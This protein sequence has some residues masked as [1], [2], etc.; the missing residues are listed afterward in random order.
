[1]SDSNKFN[2]V[3]EYFASQPELTKNAL[4]ELRECIFKTAPNAIEM[5]NYNIPAY[6]LV[7]G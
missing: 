6:A 1:M 7:E 4:I 2:T 5:F 3:E